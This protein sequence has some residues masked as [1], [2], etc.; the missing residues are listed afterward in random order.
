MPKR[1]I[2]KAYIDPRLELT[3]EEVRRI[4]DAGKINADEIEVIQTKMI[5]QSYISRSI[6]FYKSPKPRG[7][8]IKLKRVAAKIKDAQNAITSLIPATDNSDY[9]VA[10]ASGEKDPLSLTEEDKKNREKYL[11]D[12]KFSQK[13]DVEICAIAAGHILNEVSLSNELDI[14][15]DLYLRMDLNTFNLIMDGMLK[16]IQDSIEKNSSSGGK[17]GDVNFYPFIAELVE[18]YCSA[19]RHGSYEKD[20]RNFIR[21]VR[22][23]VHDRFVE[24][25]LREAA[26]NVTQSSNTDANVTNI[27]RRALDKAGY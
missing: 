8:N 2:A 17:I 19:T 14:G 27:I 4:C 6:I 21:V 7:V 20:T 3:D 10:K 1:V 13:T 12:N 23:I 22:D 15:D 25:D 5:I 18:M 9:I 24:M 26:H 11:M 16:S